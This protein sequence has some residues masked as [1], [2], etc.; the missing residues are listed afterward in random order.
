MPYDGHYL[1][2]MQLFSCCHDFLIV[3][4]FKSPWVYHCVFQSTIK[5]SSSLS[6]GVHP[7]LEVSLLGKSKNRRLLLPFEDHCKIEHKRISAPWWSIVMVIGST[8]KRTDYPPNFPTTS[9]SRHVS[10]LSISSSFVLC[11]WITPIVSSFMVGNSRCCC[12]EPRHT[13]HGLAEPT[14]GTIVGESPGV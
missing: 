7:I 11:H 14:F 8:T 13:P 10:P 3:F 6:I 2:Y 9:S 4:P 5:G 1:E 12:P